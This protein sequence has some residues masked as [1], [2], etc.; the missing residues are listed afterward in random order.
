YVMRRG[1]KRH[2]PNLVTFSAEGFRWGNVNRIPDSSLSAVPVGDQLLDVLADGNILEASGPTLYVMEGGLKRE[3]VSNEVFSACGYSSDA[4]YK[5]SD[6]K[7]A[8]I[9]SGPTFTG[10]PCPTLSPPDGYLIRG[11]GPA[12]YVM[13]G[14]LKHHIVNLEAF[15]VCSYQWGN[16]NRIADSTLAGIPTGDD[17]SGQPCP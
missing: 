14:G 11:S 17:V 1:L 5:T 13:E 7:L 15:S 12:I 9:P 8:A 6:A 16:V 2:I 3:I 4:V 10:P